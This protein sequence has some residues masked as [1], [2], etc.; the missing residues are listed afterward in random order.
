MQQPNIGPA[1]HNTIDFS[2]TH[3]G[4]F[5]EL[6]RKLGLVRCDQYDFVRQSLL[7]IAIG[8]VPLE[9][10]TLLEFR[11]PGAPRFLFWTVISVHVRYLVAIPLFFLAQQLL[12][13]TCKS[14]LTCIGEGV[15]IRSTRETI[16]GLARAAERS[17]SSPTAELVLLAAVLAIHASIWY[18]TG[19][20]ALVHDYPMPGVPT[21]GIAWYALISLPLFNFILLRGLRHWFIWTQLLWRLSRLPTRLIPTHPDRSGGI[22]HLAEP[23]H[24]IA[25][26]LAAMSCVV[27]ASWGS[28]VVHGQVEP[29]AFAVRL[30]TLILLGEL[31]ALGPL[32][33][34]TGLLLSA[35]LEGSDPYSG[36]A[37]TYT[38]LFE[39]RWVT[40]RDQNGLLGTA[41]ISGL[42][43][44]IS[45]YESL[46]R[47][48]VVP[49]GREHL[50]AVF[51]AIVL[52]MLSV[53]LLA[54]K[55]S[56]SEVL[57][58]LVEVLILGF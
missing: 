10:F 47:L 55:L 14:A 45:S 16:V 28:A 48:R 19:R 1:N 44:L 36:F 4:P 8:W 23:T 51:I 34:F 52:P 31:V 39:L 20:A 53:P 15:F 40:T 37:A 27:A 24:G 17:R 42:A 49:F 6:M 26:M 43:D 11:E 3:G 57:N 25:L 29:A 32:I 35:R 41:D 5:H 54:S 18:F 46:Q 22:G 13:R 9:L 12:E 33:P 56:I 38:R 21:F 7:M 2:L 58:H 30:I 50:L